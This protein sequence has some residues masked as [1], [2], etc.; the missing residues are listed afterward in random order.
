M[1][2]WKILPGTEGQYYFLTSVVVDHLNPVR[3]GYVEYPEHWLYS[4]ARNYILKDHS[5]ITIDC[6][7]LVGSKAPSQ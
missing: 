2:H 7:E 4:S 6:M 3:K 5:I 1:S